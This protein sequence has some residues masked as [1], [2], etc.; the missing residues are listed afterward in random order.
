MG[1]EQLKNNSI[2]QIRNISTMRRRPKTILRA[3]SRSQG[4]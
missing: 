2:I 1:R 4:V 3:K